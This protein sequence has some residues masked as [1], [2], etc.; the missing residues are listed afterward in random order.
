MPLK[1]MMMTKEELP[2]AR[3]GPTGLQSRALSTVGSRQRPQ[4]EQ[5]KQSSTLTSHDGCNYKCG[6]FSCG[7]KELR[8]RGQGDR[9][10]PTLQRL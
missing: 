10:M 6:L 7:P 9:K 3:G 4:G 2:A 5:P 1:D 8:M